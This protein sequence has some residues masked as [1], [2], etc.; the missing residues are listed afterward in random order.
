[1]TVPGELLGFLERDI[2]EEIPDELRS[3]FF[4]LTG[5]FE[6]MAFELLRGVL[7]ANLYFRG[8]HESS[9]NDRSESV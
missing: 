9:L 7:R 4:D 3:S 5:A 6:M 2:L 8:T 1:M